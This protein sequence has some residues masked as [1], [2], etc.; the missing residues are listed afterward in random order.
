MVIEGLTK[1]YLLSK[2]M[3]YSTRSSDRPSALQGRDDSLL[4]QK[5]LILPSG[6][7]AHVFVP[8]FVSCSR[9][10]PRRMRGVISN[11]N[12]RRG[13]CELSSFF[14][15][16]THRPRPRPQFE[17]FVNFTDV[18]QMRAIKLFLSSFKTFLM[19]RRSLQA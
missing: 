2:S 13:N 18:Q 11:N 14:A 12:S 10:P 8:C 7:S 4:T 3:R 15:V 16:R 9:V 19:Q 6:P 5:P 17:H 1:L